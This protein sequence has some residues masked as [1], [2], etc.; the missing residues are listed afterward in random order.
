MNDVVNESKYFSIFNSAIRFDHREFYERII[1]ELNGILPVCNQGESTAVDMSESVTEQEQ[2][3]EL[4]KRVE[5]FSEELL[6]VTKKL[7]DQYYV[8]KEALYQAILNTTAY[9]KINTLDRNLLE[10]TCDVRWWAL[11]T[12]FSDCISYYETVKVYALAMVELFD[13]YKQPDFVTPSRTKS[14][15]ADSSSLAALVSETGLPV[16]S[17]SKYQTIHYLLQ[18]VNLLLKYDS[19][20][21]FKTL[22]ANID[23]DISLLGD[24]K[25]KCKI[26]SEMLLLLHQKILFACER[27]ED[28]NSSYTLYR[29]LVITS[30]GGIVIANSNKAVR[31][32]VLGI[33]ISN[34]LWFKKALETKNGTEYYAQDL[35][36]SQVEEKLSVVYSTDN[37]SST[38]E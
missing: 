1:S 24:Q 5:N 10:R 19:S 3:T 29:D 6:V 12:A 21:Q 17:G 34:E 36:H 23:E 4:M 20:E 16:K 14:K 28:I 22:F 31:E 13:N 2:I 37:F 33:D 26:L 15:S 9:N 38:W 18:N 25:E 30:P 27:L 11:E 7:F 32:K 8:A 35:S